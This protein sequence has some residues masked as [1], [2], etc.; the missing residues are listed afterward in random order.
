M[1]A[2]EQCIERAIR[3]RTELAHNGGGYYDP[4]NDPLLK[5]ARAEL[6]Q[7]DEVTDGL[8]RATK[9]LLQEVDGLLNELRALKRQT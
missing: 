1:G 4:D 7:L 6:A 3:D 5:A 9:E 2:I 8:R